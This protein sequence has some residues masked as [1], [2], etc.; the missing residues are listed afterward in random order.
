MP[1]NQQLADGGALGAASPAPVRHA[2]AA[3]RSDPESPRALV[4]P[5]GGI[6][7]Q[8]SA[9]RPASAGRGGSF[10]FRAPCGHSACRQN[11]IDTGEVD[12]V[13]GEIEHIGAGLAQSAAI[14]RRPGATF[15]LLVWCVA[16][17]IGLALCVGAAW[18]CYLLAAAAMGAL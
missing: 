16:W 5:G 17:L 14:H 10:L 1:H 2:D 18:L 13:D 3:R 15:L 6:G 7:D 8:V 9:P 12:C 11:W 4:G